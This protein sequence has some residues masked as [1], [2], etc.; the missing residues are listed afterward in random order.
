MATEMNLSKLT[1]KELIKELLDWKNI[2]DEGASIISEKKE[3]IKKLHEQI[4]LKSDYNTI[5]TEEFQLKDEEI[6]KLKEKNRELNL[7]KIKK[8]VEDE[9]EI[10]ML[11]E[12]I[13]QMK[14]DFDSDEKNM[15]YKK[16]S[17]ELEKVKPIITHLMDTGIIESVGNGKQYYHKGF[18]DNCGFNS[19]N[20]SY[21]Y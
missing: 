4:K 17:E 21:L 6:K 20:Y 14:H 7:D 3:L 11:K 18:I 1:K 12:E 19:K 9:A 10:E 15:H 13:T 8:E 16:M 5:M 2:S